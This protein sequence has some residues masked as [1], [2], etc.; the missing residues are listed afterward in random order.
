MEEIESRRGGVWGPRPGSVY[1]ALQQLED[2]GLVRSAEAEGGRKAF[3]L[4]GEGRAYV[5]RHADEL[6]APWDAMAGTLADD[7]VDMRQLFGQVAMAASQGASLGTQAP[8]QSAPPVLI[9]ARP[10]PYGIPGQYEGQA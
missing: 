3:E 1:P 2:E 10:D 9:P 5:E 8:A 6:T 7:M 4:T